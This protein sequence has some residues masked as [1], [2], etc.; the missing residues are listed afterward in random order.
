MQGKEVNI[1]MIMLQFKRGKGFLA[2]PIIQ[3]ITLTPK[4]NASMRKGTPE[5]FS[6][7]MKTFPVYTVPA[8]YVWRPLFQSLYPYPLFL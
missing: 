8:V 6:S 5:L 3:K 7:K 4:A 2:V 1:I